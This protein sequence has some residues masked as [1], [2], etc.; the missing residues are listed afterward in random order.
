MQSFFQFVFNCMI[1]FIFLLCG[2]DSVNTKE[3]DIYILF[4]T[5]GA[6]IF[7]LVFCIL[8]WLIDKYFCV[9]KNFVAEHRFSISFSSACILTFAYFAA[10]YIF[11]Q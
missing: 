7:L 11:Y 6:V 4:G 2:E 1:G 8:M 9:R 3:E 5:L 10:T